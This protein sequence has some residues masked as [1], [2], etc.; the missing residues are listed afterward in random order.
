MQRQVSG[1]VQSHV[2][3]QEWTQVDTQVEPSS[4]H[5]IGGHPAV[6]QSMHTVSQLP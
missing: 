3:P 5:C 1:M 4:D 2:P 6:S